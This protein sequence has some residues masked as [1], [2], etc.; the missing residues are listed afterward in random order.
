MIHYEEYSLDNGLTLVVNPDKDSELIALNLIYQVGSRDEHPDQTGFAHLFEH[1]MFGGSVHIPVFDTPLQLAGGENNAF[2]NNDFTNYYVTLPHQNLETALWLESDRMLGLDFSEKGLE[3]Q[4]KVVVEEFNQRY[5]NQPYGDIWLLLRPL[6]YQKHPYQWATI[7]KE[8]QHIENARLQDVK[9]FFSTYYTP[10]NAI[11]SISGNIDPDEGYQ[12][13]QKWFGDIRKTTRKIRSYPAEPLQTEPRQLVVERPVPDDVIYI[14]FHMDR[15][16]SRDYYLADLLSDI[17]S[18][19]P[20]A[21]L[22]RK[23]IKEEQIFTEVNA[24]ITGDSDPG[25]FLLTAKPVPGVSLETARER[26][27]EEIDRLT[28]S[29]IS[30][31]ELTKV[32]NKVEAN[33][34]YGQMS[35]LNKAM[36]L[37]YFKMLGQTGMINSEIDMYQSITPAELRDFA[38]RVFTPSNS[39]TLFYKAI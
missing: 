28:I 24:F 22:T 18:S 20:S 9:D 21:R 27:L 6:A 2:T 39:S 14:A 5:L 12:L 23:F 3:I 8:I 38:M 1:L 19:G 10:D 17:L 4:K 37:G 29:E 32:K 36:S 26:L 34:T 31:R 16:L 11:L 7:G 13:V 25:L 30:E 33:Q 35:I 15:R